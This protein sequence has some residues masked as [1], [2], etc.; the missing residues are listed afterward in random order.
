MEFKQVC[1]NTKQDCLKHNRLK[2]NKNEINNRYKEYNQV[3]FTAGDVDQF[4]SKLKYTNDSIMN[5]FNY[6]YHKFKKGIFVMIKDNKLL[7]FLPFSKRGYVNEWSNLLDFKNIKEI[8]N[9][10]NYRYDWD[11]S[12]WYANNCII[13][14]EF[15]NRENDNGV[16]Q[17][18]SLITH[19]TEN[20]SIKDCYFFV[21]KRDF[22]L[23]KSDKTEPYDCIYG[24]DT[25]LV[26]YKYD[27]YAPILS[28][29]TREGFDD[30]AI[31]TWEDWTRIMSINHN[32]LFNK[33]IMI[34]E[35]VTGFCE[36]WESKKSIA[37]FRGSST[38]KGIC[39]QTNIRM[40][41]CEMKS[42]LLDVGITNWNNRPRIKKVD[43]KLV[44]ETFSLRGK[45]R[46]S[47]LS[48]K[49]QS[50]YKYI[51]NV[52]GHSAAYRLSLE[53]G[54]GS[55]I[56][57]VECDYK[58]WFQSKLQEYVHYIPIKK[59]LSDLL[60]KIEWCIQNDNKCKEIA[61]QSKI[62]YDTYLNEQGIN[63][64]MTHIL[65]SL[66]YDKVKKVNNNS[67]KYL[68]YLQ[69]NYNVHKSINDV[70][71]IPRYY[72]NVEN[73]SK[74]IVDIKIGESN[75]IRKKVTEYEAFISLFGVNNIKN[76][77]GFKH[78]VESYMYK[79][80]YLYMDK[81]EGVQFQ[82]W[83]KSKDF[84]VSKYKKYLV[85]IISVVDILQNSEYKFIHYDL[86]P[87]NV[88]IG[89]DNTIYF[90]DY[91]NS[92]CSIKMSKNRIKYKK[93]KQSTII[94][95]LS[96]L[97]KSLNTIFTCSE[98]KY[99]KGINEEDK[100]ELLH[101]SNF[102]SE[103]RYRKSKFEDLFDLRRF[104]GNMSKYDNLLF[105]EKYEL[106]NMCAKDFLKYIL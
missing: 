43:N 26:S 23:I 18:Y 103:T 63:L 87:W 98:Y 21:N 82:E 34:K 66:D 102:M 72:D 32:K 59:D 79:D 90:I 29:T 74:D 100:S 47:W 97:I 19:I 6:L 56:L 73:I 8:M 12:H 16:S 106:E 24:N 54:M 51:I 39:S 83:I 64:E 5:T 3:I 62:F 99:I 36:D 2:A 57:L 38:G 94:D 91:E 89:N 11:Y 9:K 55:V 105:M 10:M 20:N 48:A 95:V 15:P 77:L 80:G 69:K 53:L 14:N 35:D 22:P 81:I 76:D 104:V 25:P 86:S 45:T 37:V 92:S 88:L 28:M 93:Y 33:P 71:N 85:D 42:E 27:K 101:I 60:D 84:C 58:L 96:I 41:L 13:R 7:T 50:M 52:G 49:E 61:K 4:T 67:Q 65:N 1:Y 70:M 31:P 30:I 44:L 40:K 68:K 46:V 75:I 17:I 78:L